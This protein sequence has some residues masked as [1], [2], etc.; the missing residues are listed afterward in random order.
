MF[1]NKLA[2]VLGMKKKLRNRFTLIKSCEILIIKFK[3]TKNIYTVV[4][5]NKIQT[6][7]ILSN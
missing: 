2:R 4:I 7:Q 1:F 6:A 3:E 5:L